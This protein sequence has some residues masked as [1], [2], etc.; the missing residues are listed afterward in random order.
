MTL[1]IGDSET[2]ADRLVGKKLYETQVSNLS[3]TKYQ[4]PI[5]AYPTSE[6]NERKSA[7]EMHTISFFPGSTSAEAQSYPCRP[8]SSLEQQNRKYNTKPKTNGGSNKE[9]GD[10]AVPLKSPIQRI[11]QPYPSSTIQNLWF[12]FL[13]CHVGLWIFPGP[14]ERTFSLSRVSLTG[15]LAR[16]TGTDWVD[17]AESAIL[18]KTYGSFVSK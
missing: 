18:T 14:E 6:R 4:Q 13:S 8:C 5:K 16:G 11:G 1:E 9:G 3:S 17:S 2:M 15:L 10:C 7:L 12:F